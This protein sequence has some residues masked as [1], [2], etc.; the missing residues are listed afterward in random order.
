MKNMIRFL[1]VIALVAGSVLL[2]RNGIAWA[3][4]SDENASLAAQEGV[5]AV[6]QPKKR[7]HHGHDDHGTVK[8]PHGRRRECQSGHYAV[9]GIATFNV[10]DLK[11]GYCIEWE[12]KGNGFA[13]GHLPKG[14]GRFLTDFVFQRIYLNGQ[15]QYKL[16]SGDGS[17][18]TCFAVP[19]GKQVSI[20][21]YD[22][23]GARF[24]KRRGYVSWEPVET[25]IQD[26]LACANTDTSGVYALVRK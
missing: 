20:Y 4:A 17:I 2:A 18:Q 15:L 3:S 19:P 10:E 14:A 1:I 9:G 26:G 12:T 23:F 24:E 13:L 22:F 16:P 11:D 5:G 25:T 7:G 6:V 8:P 21:F